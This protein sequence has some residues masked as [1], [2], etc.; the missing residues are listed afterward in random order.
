MPTSKTTRKSKTT[1]KKSTTRKTSKKKT[2]TRKKTSVKSTKTR[3]LATGKP[4]KETP[5]IP[6]DTIS[7]IPE[8]P[9]QP[10]TPATPS[11]DDITTNISG[12]D[13]LETE[14]VPDNKSP[15]LLDGKFDISRK[16][17][18]RIAYLAANE[19]DGLAPPRRNPL[20][21]VIDSIQGRTD[22]IR[23]DIGTTEAAV[24]IL[25]RV[26]YG[27]HIPALTDRLREKVA[28]RINEMT[29]LKVVEINVRVQDVTLP[30]PTTPST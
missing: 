23:V 15:I 6:G 21:K 25:I 20:H 13:D 30:V 12:I 29:G 11:I 16:V 2:S 8:L 9:I 28:T 17:L 7:E 18:A 3:L 1:G 26:Q 24:D 27:S 10:D 5:V 19:I 4:E 14:I 22:G